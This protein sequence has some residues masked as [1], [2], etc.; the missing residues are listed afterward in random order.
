MKN[1]NPTRHTPRGRCLIEACCLAT[2]IQG[3][4]TA[5]IVH[6]G[7]TREGA[8]RRCSSSCQIGRKV[9]DRRST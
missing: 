9:A 2:A 4:S 7:L 8:P 6:G 3:T 1:G 5:A